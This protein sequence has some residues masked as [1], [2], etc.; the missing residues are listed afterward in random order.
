MRQHVT[1]IQSEVGGSIRANKVQFIKAGTLP[2]L[3][4]AVLQKPILES[5]R[6]AK[7]KK[8]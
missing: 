1:S 5:Y 8:T 3:G 6:I 4:F 7:Q 2:E